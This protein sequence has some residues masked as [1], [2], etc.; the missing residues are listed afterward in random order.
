MSPAAAQ[1]QSASIEANS[2]QLAEIVV[3]A[4]KRSENIQDAALS[5]TAYS[6]S[7]L[8]AAG[9]TVVSDL[10]EMDSTLQFSAIGGIATV[11]MR[12]LG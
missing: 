11:F 7:A 9:V 12:G 5:M 2:N 1:T 3:T 8:K 6:G 10:G 4:Q